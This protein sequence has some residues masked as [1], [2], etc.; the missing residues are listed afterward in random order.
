M[1]AEGV[2]SENKAEQHAVVVVPTPG[3]ERLAE[4]DSAVVVAPLT[5]GHER[6]AEGSSDLLVA[7]PVSG[8]ETT[9]PF[10]TIEAGENECTS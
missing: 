7:E 2:C 10:E 1:D 8:D 3:E 6:L 9:E 5:A 4:G